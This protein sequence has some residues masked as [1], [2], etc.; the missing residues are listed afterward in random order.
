MRRAPHSGPPSCPGHY[1]SSNN[2]CRAQPSAYPCALTPSWRG[3]R[4]CRRCR[5]HRFSSDCG[6]RNTQRQY[7]TRDDLCFLST[8]VLHRR[9]R[10][11]RPNLRNASRTLSSDKRRRNGKRFRQKGMVT[12]DTPTSASRK[13]CNW[14]SS[15]GESS[16]RRP[17]AELFVPAYAGS[18]RACASMASTARRFPGCP[19]GVQDLCGDVD[20]ALTR[21]RHAHNPTNAKTE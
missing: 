12:R 4:W 3:R 19:I 17:P 18:A 13:R 20:P 6:C 9:S 21:F 2:T 10:H 16:L 1:L 15:D 7:A 11:A 8:A 14:V 5:P